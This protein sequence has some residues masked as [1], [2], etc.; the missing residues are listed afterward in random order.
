MKHPTP[1]LEFALVPDRD[2]CPHDL[3]FY[4]SAYV[5]GGECCIKC[6]TLLSQSIP[7]PP[8]VVGYLTADWAWHLEGKPWTTAASNP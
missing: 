3:T 8:E 6:D 4:T 2:R 5:P 7:R 1:Q